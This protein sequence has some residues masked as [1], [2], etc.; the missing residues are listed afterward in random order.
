MKAEEKFIEKWKL[1]NSPHY[2][3]ATFDCS[4][5][6]KKDLMKLKS[7]W[8]REQR[9]ECAKYTIDQCY[10]ALGVKKLSYGD[11]KELI[12]NAPEPKGETK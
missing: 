8:C 9:E 11:M 12:R 7:E 5:E 4:K 1:Q 10:E 6:L 3:N 2:G